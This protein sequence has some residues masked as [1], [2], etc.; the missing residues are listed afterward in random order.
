M[1]STTRHHDERAVAWAGP[2]AIADVGPGWEWMDG[3][4]RALSGKRGSITKPEPGSD[5]RPD[6]DT[7]GGTRNGG[8][9]FIAEMRG[10]DAC[11][12]G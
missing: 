12:R 1:P 8:D 4:H 6:A 11:C 7:R 2:L 10:P 9:F 5:T 3:E